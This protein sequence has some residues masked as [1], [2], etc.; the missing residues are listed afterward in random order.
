MTTTVK[1]IYMSIISHSY[2]L[3][4]LLFFGVVRTLKNSSLSLFSL[5]WCQLYAKASFAHNS[6]VTAALLGFSSKQNSLE[7]EKAKEIF[8]LRC[9]Q[10]TS[11][12]VSL[13]QISP[14]FT[15]EPKSWPVHGVAKSRTLLPRDKSE[16]KY[17]K[18]H[19]LS[20]RSRYSNE[21]Q[22]TKRRGNGC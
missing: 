11:F 10:K 12:S 16:A 3:D 2:F 22:V 1:L 9:C 6:C 14:Y 4:L 13:V 18:T 5:A 17:S 15:S 7:N 19:G 20:Q 8:F 21:N